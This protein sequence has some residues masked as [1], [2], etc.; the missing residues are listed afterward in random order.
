[1][2]KMQK[3]EGGA[4]VS[5][6]SCGVCLS[7]TGKLLLGLSL[8]FIASPTVPKARNQAFNTWAFGKHSK[9]KL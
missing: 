9:S 8:K 2:V 5:L 3:Q 1:M 6:Y 4:G 7:T